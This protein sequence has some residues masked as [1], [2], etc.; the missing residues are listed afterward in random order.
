MRKRR[1]VFLYVL[2]ILLGIIM[3][4]PF[5]F[6]LSATFKTNEEI[7]SGIGLIP[8]SFSFDAFINGWQGIGNNTFGTFLLNSFKIVIPTVL[9]TIISSVLV[10]YGFARFHF[11]LKKI[12]FGIMIGTL[13]LPQAV[14]IVPRYLLFRD[15]GWLDTYLPF[16]MPALFATF[17]FFTFMLVQFMRGIPRE[18]DESAIMDGCNSFTILTKILIPLLKPALFSIGIF[19]FVWTWNDY[20]NSLIYINSVDKF[21]IS[22]GL[23]L[24]MDSEGTIAWNEMMAMSFVTILP[25]VLIFFF[26]QR[27]F[28]EGIATSG[29]KG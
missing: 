22:L 24:F 17:P 8:K 15:F 26:A 12:F 7:F 25:C 21:S 14:V 13:M 20:F 27:Y 9:F 18:L 19:Q 3:I 1:S 29:L 11:P 23:Q 16:Y 10:G 5:F 4:Y 28:V 6:M 2:L